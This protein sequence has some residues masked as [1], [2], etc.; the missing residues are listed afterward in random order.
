VALK[1]VRFTRRS[2]AEPA[3][4]EAWEGAEV[5][6]SERRAPCGYLVPEAALEPLRRLKDLVCDR[7]VKHPAR[8]LSSILLGQPRIPLVRVPVKTADQLVPAVRTLLRNAAARNEKK[9]Y[10]IGVP[11]DVFEQAA[12]RCGV[13]FPDAGDGAAGDEDDGVDVEEVPPELE[14]RLI[15]GSTRMRA[16]RQSI[17]SAARSDD[18]VLILGDTGT[19]KEVTAR[20][21]RDLDERRRSQP[22]VTVNCGA[23]PLELFESD[24]FG[25]VPGAFTGALRQGS[26]GLWR[27]AR[28]GT[29]FLDEIGDLA[30]AH[31]IKLLRA[32]EQ[33]VVRPVGSTK[34][35]A[36]DARVIA[37][38]NRDLLSMLPHEFREDLYYR[39]ATRVIYLPRLRERPEDIPLLAAQFWQDIA[40]KRPPLPG[41][42]LAELQSYRWQGNARELRYILANLNT[43]YSRKAPT[44][45]RLRAVVRL[46]KSNGDA[47]DRE[48]SQA[49]RRLDRLQH[50]Q[51][52]RV[53]VDSCHR[54]S[55][56]MGRGRLEGS[57]ATDVQLE[58]GRFITEL[59]LLNTKDGGFAEPATFEAI[60]ELE[61]ALAAFRSLLGRGQ[62]GA[63]RYGSSDLARAAARAATA[64]RR[65]QNKTLQSL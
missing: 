37:A 46:R 63:S 52:A 23:I 1:A 58:V 17:V 39:L 5:Q 65:E 47:V 6:L 35:I 62:P 28:G 15:G 10:V 50:L 31:Q 40:P 41:D 20:A 29:L 12:A 33:R 30:P 61:G 42:V 26:E 25:Y 4:V 57:A 49:L 56:S 60:S 53:A 43:M 64:V 45:S 51:R 7:G 14:Q 54:L 48:A 19:G 8:S 11:R 59:Q 24:V 36:V 38:T 9:A 55:R 18:V 27:S 22:F 13:E 2:A 32:I 3:A 44:V 34:D 21:I 16:A